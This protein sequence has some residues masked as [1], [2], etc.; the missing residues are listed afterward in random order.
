MVRDRPQTVA[1][2]PGLPPRTGV[3]CS[4][5]QQLDVRHVVIA[6]SKPRRRLASGTLDNSPVSRVVKRALDVIAAS[7]A[8][9]LAAPMCL[10]VALLIKLEDGGPVIF[11]QSRVGRHGV[12]F[13]LRKFRSMKVDAEAET[14]PT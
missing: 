3:R 10:V 5:M 9:L 6:E 4:P 1:R 11:R 12:P 13:T 14:G 8:L 7:V 2:S